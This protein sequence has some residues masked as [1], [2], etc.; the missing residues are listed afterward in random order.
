[1]LPPTIKDAP[2]SEMTAPNP[3]MSAARSAS[4]ASRTSTHRSWPREAPSACIW[5]RN[6]SGICWTAASVR[7]TTSGA[8]I[9]NWASTMA[10]GV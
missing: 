7:P 1:M 6:R 9:T 8:A 4:R 10:E 2:T 5:R 3:A